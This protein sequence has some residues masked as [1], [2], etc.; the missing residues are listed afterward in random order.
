MDN[1]RH[2]PLAT[3]PDEGW[4]PESSRTERKGEEREDRERPCDVLREEALISGGFCPCALVVS[5]SRSELLGP[6][7]RGDVPPL[8]VDVS[9]P[10]G[11]F[12]P[13]MSWR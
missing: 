12:L 9:E 2:R 13:L 4:K 10:P 8:D 6:G 1:Y 5:S 3:G 7:D 11:P